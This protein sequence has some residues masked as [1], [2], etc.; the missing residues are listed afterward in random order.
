MRGVISEGARNNTCPCVI[1]GTH[2]SNTSNKMNVVI[3]KCD[4]TAMLQIWG[5][6]LTL[7]DDASP[8]GASNKTSF[9][10]ISETLRSRTSKTLNNVLLLKVSNAAVKQVLGG[11]VYRI[12]P[13]LA[14]SIEHC[15]NILFQIGLI[16][17][18]PVKMYPVNS[19]SSKNHPTQI[20]LL[21]EI[22]PTLDEW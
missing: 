21:I 5:D 8:K 20:Y 19:T 12:G 10:V 1:S 11:Q 16:F 2:R 18:D 9:C 17:H 22:H 3:A 4:W 13:K 14:S 15:K 7:I 6:N